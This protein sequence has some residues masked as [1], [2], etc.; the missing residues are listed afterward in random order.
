M[1]WKAD[2]ERKAREKA[3]V[4]A[5]AEAMRVQIAQKVGQGKKPKPK[6]SRP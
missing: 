4:K 3:E 2:S 6:L 5:V 1:Q